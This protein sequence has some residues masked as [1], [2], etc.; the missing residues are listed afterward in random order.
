MKDSLL[1]DLFGNFFTSST[2]TEK[3]VDAYE[4]R[5]NDAGSSYR[6][7]SDD[8]CM[9][10]EIDLPGVSR[11]SVKLWVDGNRVIVESPRND[12][13]LTSR[14]T[15]N[16]DYDVMTAQAK[17]ADGLLTVWMSRRVEGSLKR[18]KIEPG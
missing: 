1:N 11:D 8:K 15:I 6:S 9:V 18:I 13:K 2:V 3:R 12:K 17:M 4:V 16:V 5:G 7:K 10:L 14:F